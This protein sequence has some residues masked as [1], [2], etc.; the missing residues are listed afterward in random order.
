MAAPFVK[1]AQCTLAEAGAALGVSQAR[2]RQ[3]EQ[4]AIRKC[5]VYLAERGIGMADLIEDVAPPP[6]LDTAPIERPL[7]GQEAA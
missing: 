6:Q 5:R 2:A 1:H 3:I 4:S 7:N